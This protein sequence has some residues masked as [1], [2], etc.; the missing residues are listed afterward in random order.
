MNEIF[1]LKLVVLGLVTQMSQNRL[2]CLAKVCQRPAF[3]TY[4]EDL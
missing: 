1:I 4:T 2:C 3:L